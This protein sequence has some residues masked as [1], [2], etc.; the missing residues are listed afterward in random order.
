[1]V[2]SPPN[3]S[4][5]ERQSRRNELTVRSARIFSG[6]PTDEWDVQHRDFVLYSSSRFAGVHGDQSRK[7]SAKAQCSQPLTGATLGIGQRATW[8]SVRIKQ[9][10]IV[11]IQAPNEP[12]DKKIRM[13]KS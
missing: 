5:I 10:E 7:D 8:D 3:C 4:N 9:I 12:K 2:I 6:S 1:M 13:C 11:L